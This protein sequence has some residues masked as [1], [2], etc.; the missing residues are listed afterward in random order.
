M[1]SELGMVADTTSPMSHLA[2]LTNLTNLTNLA[3]L[4]LPRLRPTVHPS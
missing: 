1:V 3:N 4:A 2:D